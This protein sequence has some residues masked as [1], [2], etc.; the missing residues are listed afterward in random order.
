[1]KRFADIEPATREHFPDEDKRLTGVPKRV[2]NVYYRDDPHGVRAGTWSAEK[3]SYRISIAEDTHEFFH[4]TKGKVQISNPD[5]SDPKIYGVGDVGI[6]PPG[7]AGIFEI[8]EPASK[9]WVWAEPGQAAG[10]S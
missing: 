4:I 7:F 5:G 10:Q 8:I 6:I 3:G 1:M 9:F 2:T